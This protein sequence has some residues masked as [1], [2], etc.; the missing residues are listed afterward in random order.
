MEQRKQFK[1]DFFNRVQ[2]ERIT[3]DGVRH[4]KTP[5]GGCY[6]SV[7]TVLSNLS[8]HGIQEWRQNVGEEKANQITRQAASR[9]TATHSLCE[10]YLLNEPDFLKGAMPSNVTLFKQF[11]PYLDQYVGKIYGIEIPLYS[12]LLQ[13][14]GTCDLFCQ[15]HGINTVVDFKTS[16][17][18]KKEEHIESYFYQATAYAI[19]IEDIYRVTV[20]VLGILIAV[21]EDNLQFFIKHTAD[22]RDTVITYFRNSSCFNS[23]DSI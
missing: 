4:Y 6:P 19:M 13:S 20:P 21:E 8:K 15:L 2:L 3:I 12:H 16:T 17:R 18:P 9:G 5:T 1:H 10:K 7:T 14:A 22:Y 11:Q 23:Q